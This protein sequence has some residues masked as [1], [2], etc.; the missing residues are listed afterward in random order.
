MTG[1]DLS[2]IPQVD[3]L[4]Q[5]DDAEDVIAQFGRRPVADAIRRVLTDVREQARKGVVIP[6]AD[7]IVAR[8]EAELAAHRDQ[9][10][11]R[12]IN[13]TGVILHTN[14]GR[15]PLSAA[16]RKAVAD[17]AG[18]TTIEY[19]LRTG[20][21]GSRTEHVGSLA[22]E[23]CGAEAATV[24]NNGAA[25]LL[26]VLAA[27]S[28]GR[29]TVV[30]RGELVEIGGSFRLPEIMAASG[31]ILREVGTTNKTRV[32]DYREAVGQD[33]A[34]FLA[35]HR[36]N[37]EVVGFT[38]SP[39]LSRLAEVAEAERVPLVY[40]VGSGL[41][42]DRGDGFQGEPSVEQALREGA[43][44][45]IF[46]GDK[47]LGGPQAGIIV[48]RSDLVLRCK[49]H[50]LARALRIDKLQR[51]ALEATLE[52]HLRAD[53]PVDVP[54]W[55]MLMADARSIRERAERLVAEIGEPAVVVQTRAL[56]GGG[57]LP[58]ADL[59]SF[60]VAIGGPSDGDGAGLGQRLAQR[61]QGAAEPVIA[62]IEGDRVILDLRTVPPA[63]DGLLADLLSNA[64]DELL[65]GR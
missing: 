20:T 60:G 49:R 29:E 39:E 22:A 6:R 30:S 56:A 50:P 13:A 14:L 38:E 57:S 33:T 8:A 17:A 15:A 36:S 35:V 24:V 2:R 58:G 44:L 10:L 3:A 55:A 11:S 62:R 37:Y 21:R 19:D 5:R 41:V 48:G 45:V 28:T 51:A 9:R 52:S 43:D 18:Y 34:M 64:L 23:L 32:E 12:V 31:A 16:A 27:L 7:E 46:S 4:L 25:A 59:R 47:L 65:P 40:D 61:L 1:Q 54:T 63:Q 26:L 42:R 53:P